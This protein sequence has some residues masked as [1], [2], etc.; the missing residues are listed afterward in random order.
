MKRTRRLIGLLMTA[1][2]VLAM[3]MSVFAATGT[4]QNGSLT[5]TGDKEFVGKTVDAYQIFT[6]SWVD[7]SETNGNDDNIDSSD[8]I[9]YVLNP[10]WN[11]F[12]STLPAIVADQSDHTLSQKAAEYVATFTSDANDGTSGT[13]LTLAKQMKVYAESNNISPTY[14]S[15]AATAQGDTGT[16]TIT[17]MT[18]GYYLVIPQSGST[19]TTRETDATLVNVPSEASASWNIKSSYPTV[20]KTVGNGEKNNTARIGE[21]VTFTLTSK[22]PDFTE[23]AGADCYTFAFHDTMSAGLTYKDNVTVTIGS[24]TLT[25]ADSSA[26][27]AVDGDYEVSFD[28]QNNSLTVTLGTKKTVQV[29]DDVSGNDVNTVVRDLMTLVSSDDQSG[30]A[31]KEG[32]TITLTYNAMINEDAVIA[33]TGNSNTATVQYSNDP[34]DSTATGTSTPSTTKTYTYQLT[35]DKHDDS[36]TPVQLAGA[37]FKL[38]DSLGNTIR[39]I[40]TATSDVYRVASAEEIAEQQNNQT[41]ETVTTPNSGLVLIKG[42]SAGTYLIEEVSAPTGYNKLNSDITVIVSEST[43]T[44]QTVINQDT[45][46]E[47]NVSVTTLHYDAPTYNV[48]GTDQ[49]TDSTV[50]VVNTKGTVLPTT[51][52]VGTI[53]FT[54]L[55]VGVVIFGIVITSVKKKKKE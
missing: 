29:H 16:T 38:K 3:S 17:G 26:S 2:F 9:S 44:T 50:N 39:L 6:A 20:E 52:G 46:Q 10:L 34:S 37:V 55:G 28:S 18:P 15:A 43:T 8:T 24:T 51:G 48:D 30:D 32:D 40:P 11:G 33:G 14:T 47:E 35:I 42:L 54:V 49:N 31:L 22:V 53:I 25:P 4:P 5:V 36:T 7:A 41:V 19:S 23:Y 27:P 21:I 13:V 12:F 45:Q 1:V